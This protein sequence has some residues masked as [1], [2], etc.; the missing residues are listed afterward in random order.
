MF[1]IDGQMKALVKGE[2]MP[3][4]ELR[5][6][7]IPQPQPHEVLIKVQMASIC[8]T[9][10]HIYQWDSWAARR[11]KPPLIFGHEF[12][13]KVIEMG[14]AVD[15]IAIGARVTAETH[16][17]CGRCA[18]CL[19]GER[20]VCYQTEILGVDRPGCFAEYVTVPAENIWQLP[21]M[22]SD[23]EGSIL[24]PLGNAAHTVFS[25]PIVGKNVA[26]VGCGPIGLMAVALA[27]VAGASR[28]IALDLNPYRL[29]L[30]KRMGATEIINSS[31]EDPCARIRFL[32]Q[33]PGVD[34]VCEMSGHP[35]GIQQGIEMLVPGGQMA[36]LGL[37]ANM[38]TLDLAEQ[39][40]MK[41]LTLK[42]I[43]GRQL[44]TTWQQVVGILQRRESTFFSLLTHQFALEE[45]EQ[46]FAQMKDG[47]CGKVTLVIDEEGIK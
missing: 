5:E 39:V 8:G 46:A 43:T 11:I 27:K 44:Y 37:P 15:G 47:R 38:V 9:D 30:A 18:A 36:M 2:P 16:V 13:G 20:H 22:L 7:P 31:Q 10:L 28:V 4:A 41:G 3:G 24:E 32:T 1:G 14:S 40:V 25:F 33:Q 35:Q 23:Q 26:I 19:R 6:L 21:P 17:T 12:A 42:G 29:Q 45:F 34:V